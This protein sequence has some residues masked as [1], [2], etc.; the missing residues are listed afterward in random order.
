MW[1]GE[2][3]SK[4]RP[5][6][7]R[8]LL[9][10]LEISVALA[11]TQQNMKVFKVFLSAVIAAG[12]VSVASAQTTLTNTFSGLNI[13]IPDGQTTSVSDTR[14][15]SFADQTFNFI[16]NLEVVLTITNGYNGDLYAYLTHGDGHVVLLNRVGRT[17]SS[18][19]GYG[20]SGM[21]VILSATGADIHSYQ[22]SS[23][24]FNGAG[25]LTGEWGADGRTNHPAN[26]LNTDPPPP[27]LLGSFYG[28]DPT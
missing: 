16:T 4:K 25:Q 7:G 1:S 3:S 2:S 5:V 18:P 15:L 24:T 6:S 8:F 13:V 28:V 22:G 19:A 9:H 20:D 11:P 26:G 27:S 23:P 21:D 12:G 17:S 14:T 10:S